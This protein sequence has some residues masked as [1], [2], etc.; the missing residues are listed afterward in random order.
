M[1]HKTWWI[2]GGVTLAQSLNILERFAPGDAHEPANAH[3]VIEALRRGF[4]D[5]AL[6]LGDSDFVEV[7]VYLAHGASQVSKQYA[8]IVKIPE[9]S[10]LKDRGQ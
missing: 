6:Y 5:R 8:K 2:G 1:E 10:A 7:P 3:L 9:D 4:Q